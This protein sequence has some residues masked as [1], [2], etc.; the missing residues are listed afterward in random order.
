MA[1]YTMEDIFEDV[2]IA[3]DDHKFRLRDRTKSLG[4]KVDALEKRFD[5]VREDDDADEVQVTEVM[6]DLLDVFLEPVAN[7]SDGTRTHAKTI[8]AKAY[9]ADRIG[10]DRIVSLV[11]FCQEKQ[12][13][14]VDPP[15]RPT[16]GD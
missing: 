4:A 2:V 6:I 1:E 3:L 15:S 16:S 8:L 5:A 10:S 14:R 7:G 11:R 9:K 13:E 12:A